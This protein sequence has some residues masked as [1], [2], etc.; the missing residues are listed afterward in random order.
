MD[1][2]ALGPSGQPWSQHFRHLVIANSRYW[3]RCAKK[4]LNALRGET[5]QILQ[6]L[7]YALILPDAWASARELIV[8]LSPTMIRQGQVKSW[9]AILQKSINAS[10]T[11]NDKV[12]IELRQQLGTL[13]RLQ[14]RLVE[15]EHCLHEALSLC[16]SDY[17]QSPYWSVLTQLALVARLLAHHDEALRLAQQVMARTDLPATIKAE[18]LNV[19]GLV[20]YDQRQWETALSCF[21]QALALYR[22]TEETYQIA[23]LLT[24]RGVVFQREGRWDEAEASYQEAIQTFQNTDDQTEQFKAVMNLGNIF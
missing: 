15:A 20:A 21:E 6:G 16:H 14:G 23:R 12:E 13:Y 7:T 2:A 9:E 3:L 19:K 24:N 18:A 8:Y 10:I 22:S 5:P 17:P 11:A 4:D 1:T